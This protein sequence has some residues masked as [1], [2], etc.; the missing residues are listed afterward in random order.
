MGGK[1]SR[2][3][4]S[5][6]SSSVS[7]FASSSRRESSSIAGR[8]GSAVPTATSPGVSV[9]STVTL[10]EEDDGDDV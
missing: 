7:R 6:A 5:A 2:G 8:P 3:R 10:S 4:S 9:V 1:P